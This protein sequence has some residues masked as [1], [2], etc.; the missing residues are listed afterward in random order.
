MDSNASFN[1]AVST[2]KRVRG[3]S[4]PP[5]QPLEHTT[6]RT[7]NKS[8]RL[9]EILAFTHPGEGIET[10]PTPRPSQTAEIVG[11]ETTEARNDTEENLG[12]TSQPKGN[13]PSGN[14]SPGEKKKKLPI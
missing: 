8:Q 4:A 9:Q 1:V 13:E 14:H 5:E 7:K 3:I 11:T 12:Q 10:P 2:S 6:K